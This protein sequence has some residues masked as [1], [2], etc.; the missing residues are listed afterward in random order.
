V[1]TPY[2]RLGRSAAAAEPE[3]PPSEKN[4]ELTGVVARRGGSHG[5]STSSTFHTDPSPDLPLLRCSD[6]SPTVR[7]DESEQESGHPSDT[8]HIFRA[9][10]ICC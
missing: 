8:V 3:L 10:E 7:G 9:T 6:C 2:L 5:V 1:G 4:T